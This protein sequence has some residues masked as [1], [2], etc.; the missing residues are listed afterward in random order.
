[1]SWDIGYLFVSQNFTNFLACETSSRVSW[2]RDKRDIVKAFLQLSVIGANLFSSISNQGGVFFACS[3]CHFELI[4]LGKQQV[5]RNLFC[6]K[7]DI[8]INI[9]ITGP[10]RCAKNRA[11]GE[12]REVLRIS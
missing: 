8:E 4:I 11:T 10:E 6:G 3:K 2:N 1:M 12:R 5:R 7:C 9:K